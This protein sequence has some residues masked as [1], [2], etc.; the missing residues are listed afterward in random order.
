MEASLQNSII[1]FIRR[2]PEFEQAKLNEKLKKKW[3]LL[4]LKKTNKRKIIK[5]LQFFNYKS[6]KI[7]IQATDW[8]QRGQEFFC[9]SHFLMHVSWKIWPQF[10]SS[11]PFRS[12]KS[13]IQ[14]EQLSFASCSLNSRT[15]SF[16]HRRASS[17]CDGTSPFWR[18]WGSSTIRPSCVTKSCGRATWIRGAIFRCCRGGKFA[19]RDVSD[20]PCCC[21]RDTVFWRSCIDDCISL[22]VSEK[23]NKWMSC[24][25]AFSLFNNARV[26][27]FYDYLN[28]D[29]KNW[30]DCKKKY[31]RSEFGRRLLF[32]LFLADLRLLLWFATTWI[33]STNAELHVMQLNGAA[34]WSFLLWQERQK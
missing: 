1:K 17:S 7:N 25:L 20:A 16:S 14:I 24:Y 31:L 3:F 28:C 11:A 33:S 34:T 22:R 15:R 18:R 21:P 13:L 9:C 29:L 26:E 2:F 30:W 12:S 4:N 32:S 5:I 23:E 27:K 6:D 8:V 19:K 10:G